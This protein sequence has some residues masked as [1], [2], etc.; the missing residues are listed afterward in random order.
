[1][2]RRALCCVCCVKCTLYTPE[3]R[4]AIIFLARLRAPG[5]SLLLDIGPM[6]TGELPPTA[7]ERLAE[8]GQWMDVNGVAI[9]GTAPIFPYAIN[10][11][12]PPPSK[13]STPEWKLAVNATAGECA[14]CDEPGDNT[15]MAIEQC[16]SYCAETLPDCNTLNFRPPNTC[17]VKRCDTP[18]QPLVTQYGGYDVWIIANYPSVAQARQW[19]LSRRGASS[20]FAMLLI[21]GTVLPQSSTLELPF[22]VNAPGGID[23]SWPSGSLTSVSLLGAGHGRE[24]VDGNLTMP[25]GKGS[26]ASLGDE[27]EPRSQLI[28]FSWSNQDGL[29]LAIEPGGTVAQPYVA[30]FELTYSS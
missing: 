27:R 17:I 30:V 21:N 2:P 7:L 10:V 11:T 19:R 1:M 24:R 20:V 25:S 16:K 29:V 12:S 6:A 9:H 14:S 15:A 5:G 28:L 22:V 8:V 18:G 26:G 3:T 23:G 4:L 13:P